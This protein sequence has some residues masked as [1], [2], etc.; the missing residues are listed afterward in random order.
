M[1]RYPPPHVPH[2]GRAFAAA[3]G[4]LLFFWVAVMA[5]VYFWGAFR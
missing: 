2:S 5:V 3:I 1:T 4:A